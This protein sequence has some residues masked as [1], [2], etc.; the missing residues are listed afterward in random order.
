MTK[1]FRFHFWRLLGGGLMRAAKFCLV[2]K[3]RLC[4]CF[5]CYLLLDGQRLARQAIEDA[6]RADEGLP[7][8][9]RRPS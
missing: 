2:R 7:K 6:I 3:A 8:L 9:D 5:G 4:G 1:R